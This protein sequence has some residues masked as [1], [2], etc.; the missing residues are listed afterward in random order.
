MDRAP[1][2]GP[3]ARTGSF[4]A[5]PAPRPSGRGQRRDRGIPSSTSEPASSRCRPSSGAGQGGL[6]AAGLARQAQDLARLD[7][8]ISLPST[9]CAPAPPSARSQRRPGRR[10]TRA[11]SAHGQQRS[12]AGSN[13]MQSGGVVPAPAATKCQAAR[14]GQAAR[15]DRAAR[16]EAAARR[17]R[18]APTAPCPGIAVNPGAAI[19][20]ARQQRLRV[21]MVSDRDS[22]C[23]ALA[24]PPPSARRRS[25][26]RRRRAARRR[27]DRASRTAVP[28]RVSATSSLQQ[29]QDLLLRRHVQRR[30]RLVRHDQSKAR[31]CERRHDQ[32]PLPLPAGELGAGSG[33]AREAGSGQAHAAAAMPSNSRPRW[34]PGRRVVAHHLQAT[35]CRPVNS[36]FSASK[37]NPAG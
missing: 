18:A 16:R 19:R 20:M 24:R 3:G 1:P 2:P 11:A 21:G 8:Q 5:A 6:A 7:V 31:T 29:Q 12:H 14:D 37:A 23:P 15:A 27:P 26:Q 25:P 28:C 35:G 10:A 30:G 4:G 34:S 36:G 33:A 32:Q 9:A 22:T 13:R 17:H